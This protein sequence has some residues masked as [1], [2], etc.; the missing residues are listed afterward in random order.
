MFPMTW[1]FLRRRRALF[2]RHILVL[3]DVDDLNLIP[4][5]HLKLYEF[6]IFA[7]DP[8]TS[9][10]IDLN[11][12][13]IKLVKCKDNMQDIRYNLK[14]AYATSALGHV[15]VVN[16]R[17]PM[18]W[19]LKEWYVQSYLE[20]YQITMDSFLW[21]VPHVCVF[22]LDNT[23]ITDEEEVQIR[24]PAVYDSLKCLHDMGCV[25][26]LWSYGNKEHVSH[27][28]ERTKLDNGIFDVV[29]C[30]GYKNS[31][32]I[33]KNN[34]VVIDNKKKIAYVEKSFYSDIDYKDKSTRLPKSP[35]VILYYLRKLGINYTKSLTLVDDLQTNDY[36]YD[37][38]VKVKKSIEPL[39]DWDVYHDIILN[40]ITYHDDL[41]EK[42]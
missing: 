36:A 32:S 8:K 11:E 12:Y 3:I 33:D 2:K 28:M 20:V 35:R 38:F 6:V 24:S 29:I 19:F 18:Y 40:N 30:E 39:D 13:S 16:E 21:E 31:S 26:I 23:L 22:D 14:F 41:F 5:R 1:V 15:Y 4:F 25:L 34:R 42:K 10:D 27:S 9:K 7:F 17:T 37:Y